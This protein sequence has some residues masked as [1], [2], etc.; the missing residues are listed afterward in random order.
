MVPV[1]EESSTSRSLAFACDSV[2]RA[3]RGSHLQGLVES[4]LIGKGSLGILGCVDDF[5][6]FWA[7]LYLLPPPAA[8]VFWG[9]A[10]STQHHEAIRYVTVPRWTFVQSSMR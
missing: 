3:A 1:G 8:A 5:P 10:V 9:F 2:S 6:L 4:A 7:Y